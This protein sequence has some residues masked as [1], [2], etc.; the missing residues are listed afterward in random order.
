[1]HRTSMCIL[2]K[3][4]SGCVFYSISESLEITT[5]FFLLGFLKSA[6]IRQIYQKGLITGCKRQ[7]PSSTTKSNTVCFTNRSRVTA[8]NFSWYAVFKRELIKK[9]K[10]GELV[11]WESDSCGTGNGNFSIYS[12]LKNPQAHIVILPS[13]VPKSKFRL[14]NKL[15]T[16]AVRA[17]GSACACVPVGVFRRHP[18]QS[19]G[20]NVNLDWFQ[21]DKQATHHQADTLSFR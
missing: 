11:T 9:W 16:R 3:T 17:G 1:M 19:C 2:L 14:K 4:S 5:W 20:G 6:S 8:F 12:L 18:A 21:G 15:L 10:S 13:K 7:T